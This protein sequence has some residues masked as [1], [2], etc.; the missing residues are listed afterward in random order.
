MTTVIGQLTTNVISSCG[1]KVILNFQDEQLNKNLRRYFADFTRNADF[2]NG[3][4]FNHFL[5]RIL[6][7]VILCGDCVVLFDDGAIEGSG[8]LL[9]FESEEI[10]QTAPEAIEREYGEGAFQVQGKVYSRN[11]RHIGTV[12]SRSQRGSTSADPS[13]CYFLKKD[14]D[15]NPL[16][17]KWFQP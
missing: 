10:V 8:K 9:L 7:E 1:G 16:V 12:V 11:G 3:S 6:R 2:Y 4:S 15:A 13:K 14:P 17:C 5:K